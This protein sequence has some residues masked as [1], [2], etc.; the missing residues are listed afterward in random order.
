MHETQTTPAEVAA[1]SQ[2]LTSP[3]L[4]AQLAALNSLLD[5]ARK[6]PVRDP[7]KTPAME[8]N[9]KAVG[10]QTDVE[11]TVENQLVIAQLGVASALFTSLKAKDAPT[12]SHSLRVALSCSAWALAHKF[13]EEVR[14]EIEIAALLH[15]IGKIGV[16]DVVLQKP[17]PLAEKEQLL[18][19]RQRHIGL[20]I[21]TAFGASQAIID[22]VY[23]SSA[24]FTG[25]DPEFDR[26]GA[27]L[28]LGGRMLAVVDAFDAMTSDRVYRRAYSRERALTELFQNAGTQFDPELVKDFYNR[29]AL[30]NPQLL[31]EVTQRWI[32]QL[33]PQLANARWRMGQLTSAPQDPS[34]ETLFNEKLFD[35]L[36]DGLI[37]VDTN[38]QIMRWNR[39][40]EHLT[41]IPMPSMLHK[42]WNPTLVQLR[43]D[44]EEDITIDN[45]PVYQATS[46]GNHV[47]Q[48]MSI[49]GRDGKRTAV[50]MHIIPVTDGSG[51]V[52]G[53]TIVFRDM[54]SEKYLQERVEHLHRKAT[55]DSLTSLHNRAEFDTEF[56]KLVAD[57]LMRHQPCS[58]IICDLDKFKRVNDTYGH[59]A[60]DQVLI[61]FAALLKRCSR[62]GDVT[63]RYGGEEFVM[64][65]ADCDNAT[66]AVRAEE[67]RRECASTRHPALDT[68]PITC[69]FGVTELQLGDTP[70]TM[71][72]RAD[73]AVYE[74]KSM[75]RNTVVQLGSGIDE[76][77]ESQN[78]GW[79]SS[80][81]NK[82]SPALLLERT[83]VTSVP[84]NVAIEKLSGFVVDHDADIVSVEENR[85][86]ISLDS[87][88][89]TVQR[90]R[91][92][93][94]VQFFT[95]LTFVPP[96]V[97]VPQATPDSADTVILVKIR[98]KK[99]R[100]RRRRNTLDRA[101]QILASLKSYLVAQENP[102][103][104][105]SSQVV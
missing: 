69:S 37:F 53:A 19:K 42:T 7:A 46:T 97:D 14:S 59:Q 79:W 83:L 81:W 78:V 20:S 6:T 13:P 35:N 63:A 40:A 47:N 57:H 27:A 85:V 94:S 50:D 90:R 31:Q 84:T 62:R 67:I 77:D 66:A 34:T 1:S 38:Q 61:S 99:N 8:V 80:W 5:D 82:T 72:R 39:T 26:N 22:N 9:S 43:D 12:A 33:D 100:D 10:S 28:P 36:Q 54:S 76:D 104:K 56:R 71:L 15:D 30:D 103:R 74:A 98:P 41:G 93:R 86:L 88:L 73:R 29:N 96:E 44:N 58:L 16:P 92:D 55:L 75:G 91:G 65:C 48:R 18:I 4:D 89:P 87:C 3:A 51:V 24:W 60:G 45:C 2:S 68:K 105:N 11:H 101:Q 70:E 64:L 52:L 95:E 49:A 102:L 25:S 32:S 23:Y 21:L 17:A